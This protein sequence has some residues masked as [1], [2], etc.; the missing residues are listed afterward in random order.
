MPIPRKTTAILLI[1]F[2]A[3]ALRAD[4]PPL[5][6]TVM[7]PYRGI[8]IE[9]RYPANWN[10]G[11]GGEFIY[12]TPS[13]GFP[14]SLLAYGMMIGRFVPPPESTLED[15]TDQVVEQFKEWNQNVGM[16]RYMGK[17]N[18]AGADATVVDLMNTSSAGG[19]ETDWLVT[20]LRPNGLVTYFVAVA[21]ERDFKDYRPTFDK[22]LAS[23]RFPG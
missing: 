16:V 23:V 18:I 1:V 22:I 11:V 20:V 6:S 5:P 10:V 19:M 4:W 13:G 15:V 7:V 8:D 3:V 17:T 12:V 2:C 14:E 21:P 9:F